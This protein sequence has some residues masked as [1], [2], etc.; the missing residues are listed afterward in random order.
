MKLSQFVKSKRNWTIIG[1]GVV[2]VL[3]ALFPERFE[4]VSLFLRTIFGVQ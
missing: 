3:G 2:N 4:G 1:M